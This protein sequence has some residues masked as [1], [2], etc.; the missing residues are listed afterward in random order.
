MTNYLLIVAQCSTRSLSSPAIYDTDICFLPSALFVDFHLWTLKMI[1]I[2]LIY[3]CTV[4]GKCTAF[5]SSQ[6]R[7]SDCISTV[8][9][10]RECWSRWYTGT[11]AHTYIYT[12]VHTYIYEYIH[13]HT[14]TGTYIHL[15]AHTCRRV[16]RTRWR[17]G[18]VSRSLM[19]VLI[20]VS[21]SLF[22][23]NGYRPLHALA[24]ANPSKEVVM[25]SEQNE[26]LELLIACGADLNSLDKV[27]LWWW[28][29]FVCRCVC[30]FVCVFVCVC[31]CVCTFVCVQACVCMCMYICVCVCVCVCAGVCI[32]EC[33]M[34]RTMVVSISSYRV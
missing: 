20:V 32:Y 29:C 18:A 27:T 21:F 26:T 28:G 3:V 11:E 22:I 4:G 15:Y 16:P 31:P 7:S 13:V 9:A 34:Y 5:R 12:H 25:D 23:Q 19:C 17:A 1:I 6:S 30:T 14:H 8:E 2:L 33:W 10:R 24:R